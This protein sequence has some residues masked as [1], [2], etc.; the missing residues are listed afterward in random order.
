[1]A[2]LVCALGGGSY[3]KGATER[4]QGA[5]D[6]FKLRLVIEFIVPPFPVVMLDGGG[7]EASEQPR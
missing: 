5:A 4:K 2:D 7:G 1:M 6:V 3:H